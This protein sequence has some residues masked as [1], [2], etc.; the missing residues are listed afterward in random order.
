MSLRTNI[1][2]QKALALAAAA[3]N[4]HEKAAA[5]QAA[6]RV[7]DAHDIDPVLIPNGSLYSRINFADNAVLKKLREEWQEAHPDRV[8]KVDRSGIT[9]W[10]NRPK[11]PKPVNTK[12]K[13]KPVNTKPKRP[14]DVPLARDVNLGLGDWKPV[15]TTKPRPRVNTTKSKNPRSAD[16]H[17]E[18][19]RDRHSPGYM[20]EY[21]RRRRAAKT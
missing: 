7:M 11:A 15:N 3:S 2:F 5:E 16:R 13:P 12:P 6:R 4:Q 10:A 18:P 17:L 20:R 21:M 19:N 14:A 8:Y 9:R 1:K